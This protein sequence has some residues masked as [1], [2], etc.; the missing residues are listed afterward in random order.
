[1]S[2]PLAD[3][4]GCPPGEEPVAFDRM[5]VSLRRSPATERIRDIATSLISIDKRILT[6][7]L[8]LCFLFIFSFQRISGADEG[9]KKHVLVLNSYHKGLSWTDNIVKAVESALPE[10]HN[11]EINYEYMDTKR[12]FSKAYLKQV[13]ELYKTK[14][15]KQHFDAIIVSDSDELDLVTQYRRDFFANGG[16]K[17]EFI[18]TFGS[19]GK[20]IGWTRRMSCLQGQ[21]ISPP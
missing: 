3:T 8:L 17:H 21:W 11:I 14:Y 6:V 10:A 1:L 16:L 2:A 15:S 13:Y 20:K 5:R 19:L 7:P 4:S 12:Y 9:P 18:N